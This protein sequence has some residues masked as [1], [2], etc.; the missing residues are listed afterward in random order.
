MG[1]LIQSQK[2]KKNEVEGNKGSKPAKI[3][4]FFALKKIKFVFSQNF[5][6]F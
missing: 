6:W 1:T 4:W 3:G 2:S 5:A